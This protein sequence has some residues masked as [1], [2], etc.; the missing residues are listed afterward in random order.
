MYKK[1]VAN[2]IDKSIA[3]IGFGKEGKSSYN[4][5]R[6][7]LPNKKI[8]IIDKNDKLLEQNDYLKEDKNV[9]VIT[10]ENY[11]DSINDYDMIIKSPGVKIPNELVKIVKDKITS[12]LELLLEID[13]NNIIGITGTKGKSTTSSLLYKIIK[14]QDIDCL[15]LGNVGNPIL[16]YI[17]DIKED[18]ILVIECSSYQLEMIHYSPHIGLVLNLFE[19][20]LIYHIN[21]EDYWHSKLNMFRYQTNSDY[22]L[23]DSELVNVNNEISKNHFHS[24]KLD[25]YKDFKIDDNRVIF[26]NRIIYD[27]SSKREIIGEHNFKNILFVLRVCILLGLDLEKARESIETFKPLKHRM[28]YFGTYNGVKYYDDTIATIPEATINCIEALKEVDTLIFGGLDRGID[29]S[30][31]I[32]YLNNSKIDNIIAMP[33][34]GYKIAKEL[35]NKKVFKVSTLEEAVI[36][37]KKVTKKICVL[38]PA[39]PS[40]N[41][42]K[43]FEEKGDLFKELV[44]KG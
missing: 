40:Y 20:H 42:F 29:Y 35:V 28:E 12:Q 18:T 6:R 3:I 7:Y 25:I 39:A 37:A 36:T 9:I 19:D 34:T 14:D 41:A 15:L 43:N 17:E 11:L 22:M 23:Y 26:E 38:S 13:R 2:I 5:I 27:K 44:K 24:N 1:I 31:L 33:D 16:D 10:G 8:A 32:D 4:F 21:L 30:I